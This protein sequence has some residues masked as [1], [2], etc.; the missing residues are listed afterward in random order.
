LEESFKTSPAKYIMGINPYE[1]E[2]REERG[3]EGGKEES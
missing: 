2:G 3:K 1:Q